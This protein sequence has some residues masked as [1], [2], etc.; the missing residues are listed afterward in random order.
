MDFVIETKD[1]DLRLTPEQVLDT[2][3]GKVSDTKKPEVDRLVSCL[4]DFLGGTKIL[5]GMNSYEL[6]HMS[7]V[8]GYYY[9]LFLQK[10]K[11][12]ISASEQVTEDAQSGGGDFGDSS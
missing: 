8:T 5:A 12:S 10:N 7:F 6:S 4:V 9:H 11:V 2:L 3:L 1:G